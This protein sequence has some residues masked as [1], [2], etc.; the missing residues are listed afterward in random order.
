MATCSP[1]IPHV[2]SLNFGHGSEQVGSY[3][4][5]LCGTVQNH[6]RLVYVFFYPLVMIKP[7]QCAE[8]DTEFK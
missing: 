4:H 1:P 7:R 2:M 3:L 6:D 8:S 5:M